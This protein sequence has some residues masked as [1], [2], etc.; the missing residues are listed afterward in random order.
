MA[1]DYQEAPDFGMSLLISNERNAKDFRAM[2]AIKVS[3]FGDLPLVANVKADG[4]P[5]LG[6]LSDEEVSYALEQQGGIVTI[7]RVMIIN[8]DIGVVQKIMSR[9]P[10]AARITRARKLWKLFL[11]NATYGGDG[12]AIFHVDHNNLGSTAYAV[13]ELQVIRTAMRKQ[14]EPGSGNRIYLSNKSETVAI[15]TDLWGTATGINKQPP[16]L[17]VP[18]PMFEYFGA[19]NERIFENPFQTDV[20]D[21]MVF[22][23]P[24]EVDIAEIAYLNGVKEPEMFVANN[25][26]AGQTFYNDQN[27]FKIRQEDAVTALDYRGVYKEVVAN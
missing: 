27:Q 16:T 5:D 13:A 10:R 2:E 19:G 17:A 9:I 14:T 21:Y 22:A 12:K 8:D 20:T 3:Y 25:P 11:D 15:P 18:N 26:T 6:V 24:K 23:N 1:R 7:D 4:W